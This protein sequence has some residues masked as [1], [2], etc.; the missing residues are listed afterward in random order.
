MQP[1]KKFIIFTLILSV[2]IVPVQSLAAM[3]MDQM[4][5]HANAP[6]VDP[7]SAR[8]HHQTT[9]D[10]QNHKNSQIQSS[11]RQVPVDAAMAAQNGRTCDDNQTGCSQCDNC[12]HCVNLLDVTSWRFT[13]LAGEI[14]TLPR[15]IVP[16]PGIYLL[17]RPPI[18]S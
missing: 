12:S 7:L 9:L 2:M 3:L 11:D 13:G 14:E 10:H 18:R 4:P 6:Q 15:G 1:V 8:A 16:S 5:G 17:L